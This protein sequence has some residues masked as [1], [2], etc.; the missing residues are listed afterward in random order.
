MAIYRID[1]VE[2]SGIGQYGEVIWNFPEAYNDAKDGDVLEIQSNVI[3]DLSSYQPYYLNNFVANND[4]D[5]LF[6][7]GKRITIK[8]TTGSG[9]LGFFYADDTS[10]ALKDIA[11]GSQGYGSL[12]VNS[13]FEFD[14]VSFIKT[15]E[16][17]SPSVELQGSTGRI[18]NCFFNKDYSMGSTSGLSV[19]N[20]KLE[21]IDTVFNSRIFLMNN[22]ET[23]FNNC[24]QFVSGN[25]ECDFIGRE[26]KVEFMNSAFLVP[27][28]TEVG[29]KYYVY[30]QNC[31]FSMV[32]T[33]IKGSL[34]IE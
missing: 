13:T 23:T 5:L 25:K 9:I 11:I 7:L 24:V 22:A 31:K 3:V 10:V 33:T 2:H 14:N 1:N 6:N 4:C 26:S 16:D 20:S 15:S 17:G 12:F 8:G 18:N 30:L 32:N 34:H 27:E 29:D 19:V 21:V 28:N